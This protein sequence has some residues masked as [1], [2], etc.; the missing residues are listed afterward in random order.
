MSVVPGPGAPPPSIVT[1]IGQQ[2]LPPGV[3]WMPE[4]GM[5]AAGLANRSKLDQAGKSRLLHSSAVILGSGCNPATGLGSSTGLIVGQV[6]SGKTMSFTNV[7]GLARDNGFPLVILVAGNKDPLLVQSH[8]RLSKDLH[9]E[10]GE[11]LPPWKMR[12]NIRLRD[13]HDEQM[14]RQ[15]LANWADPKMEPDEK[16]TMLLTVLKQNNRLAA[17]TELLARFDLSRTPVLIIDDEADQASL[18]T[19][20]NQNAESTTY[21]RL[22]ELRRALPVP[23]LPPIH[24]HAA[25]ASIGEHRR[26]AI[27]RFRPG[28]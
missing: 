6:Q 26:H 10:E 25:G 5:E 11:G 4:E 27:P 19:K 24:G 28:A 20:I 2:A 1:P 18:N 3:K 14:I 8:D 22:R 21:T 16:A 12:K 7:I 23:H 9:V 17:L 15:T 13:A